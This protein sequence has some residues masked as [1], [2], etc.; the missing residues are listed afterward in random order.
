L[1][2]TPVVTQITYSSPT[3]TVGT[4]GVY[5]VIYGAAASS[6]TNPFLQLVVNGVAVAQT[7]LQVTALSLMRTTSV[8]L[9]LTANSTLQVVN[10][11]AGSM[12]LNVIINSGP[13]AYMSITKI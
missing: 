10:E 6:G 7:G 8:I 3:V 4:P 11:G 12:T 1:I 9:S 5:Q 2:N 13:A